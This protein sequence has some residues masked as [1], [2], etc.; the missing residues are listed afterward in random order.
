M[1][2]KALLVALAAVAV[3]APVAL[4]DKGPPPERGKSPGGEPSATVPAPV[5]FPAEPG[6]DRGGD[7]GR[8]RG[9]RPNDR[10]KDE[11]GDRGKG[12]DRGERPK[13][14]PK[15]DARESGKGRDRGKGERRCGHVLALG[16]V[17][18]I[19]DGALT[20][21][22]DRSNVQELVGREV[23]FT[24]GERTELKGGRPAV[25]SRVLVQGE[26]CRTPGR[27]LEGPKF[28]ALVVMPKR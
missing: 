2:L 20:V 13:D 25:G 8:D 3:C 26:G 14:R 18:A 6:K 7:K 9:E 19:G 21:S 10:P 4:A 23:A 5:A 11:A 17:V 15:D 24:I 12:R 22:V 28:F 27:T 1:R 16:T